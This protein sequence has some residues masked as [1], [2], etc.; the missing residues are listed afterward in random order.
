MHKNDSIFL[1]FFNALIGLRQCIRSEKNA[2]F[3]LIATLFVILTASLLHL[4]L[5]NWLFLLLAISLVWI[6]ELFN[7]A[8]E[9]LF[10]F[11]EPEIDPRVK[12][13]KDISS[14]AVLIASL[15]SFIVGILIIVPPIIDLLSL[16]K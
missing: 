2:K 15:F 1:S 8:I 3:H 6:T 10:D 4:S 16:I 11:L 7:T 12:F 9:Y 5:M 14:A 13:A